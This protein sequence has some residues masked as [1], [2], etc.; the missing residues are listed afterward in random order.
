MIPRAAIT[1]DLDGLH[2]DLFV[3]QP[4]SAERACLHDLAS[5]VVVPRILE[6]LGGLGVPA[7]FFAIGDD[8]ERRPA[9]FRAIAAAGHEV[10][11][12]TMSHLRDFSRQSAA[13]I[14]TEVA[15]GDE[16]IAS[17]TGDKPVGFRAPGYTITPT[18]IDTLTELGYRYDSSV[19]PSWSYSALK[20][21]FRWFARPAYRDF[22]VP[23]ELSCA[24]APRLPY[25][26]A[27]HKLFGSSQGA[28]VIEIPLTTITPLQFPFIHGLTTRV[29]DAGR[30]LV[31]WAAVRRPFVSL[32]FHDME[33]A[34]RRDLGSLP[35]SDL[36]RPHLAIP[37]QDRLAR[38]ST[39]VERVKQTHVIATLKT[40]AEAG[41]GEWG[42]GASGGQRQ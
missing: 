23:Q 10:A 29:P 16:A 42:P 20:H 26:I 34:D 24:T 38:L 5:A 3:Q 31:E 14:R 7:T 25:P 37:I 22:L 8:V 21:A 39:L 18:V 12:H 15:R 30:R 41:H 17:A 35:A 27:P 28:A 11:N 19:V 13:T 33:F 4:T 36:T 2:R 9:L 6:W 32:S 1:F 40:T